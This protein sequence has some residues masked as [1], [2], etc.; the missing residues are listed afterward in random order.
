M[1][2]SKTLV[3]STSNDLQWRR[4]LYMTQ[5]AI[6]LPPENPKSW[7]MHLIRSSWFSCT[8]KAE[9]KKQIRKRKRNIKQD[10][11]YASEILIVHAWKWP[12]TC[13]FSLRD[14]C[15]FSSDSGSRAFDIARVISWNKQETIRTNSSSILKIFINVYYQKERCPLTDATLASPFWTFPFSGVLC[16]IQVTTRISID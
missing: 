9:Y 1:I 12:L 13:C 2:R 3:L 15:G 6:G 7:D 8:T 4:H 10:F 5:A 16:K 14:F 11:N